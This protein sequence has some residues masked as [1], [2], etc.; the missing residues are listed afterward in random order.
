MFGLMAKLS[1]PRL[2]ICQILMIYNKEVK[3][4]YYISVSSTLSYNKYPPAG[5][6][7]HKALDGRSA[8]Y[9]WH[10]CIM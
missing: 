8:Q 1:V 5:Y 10:H 9:T 3:S 2:N 4:T 7:P 6:L